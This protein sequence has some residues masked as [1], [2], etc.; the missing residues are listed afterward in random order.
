MQVDRMGGKITTIRPARESE[1]EILT[2]V[3]M[4]S[5][6]HWGYDE[7]FM[8]SCR[9]ELATTVD[10]IRDH[11]V[12]AIVDE[13]DVPVGYYKLIPYPDGGLELSDLFVPR[14]HARN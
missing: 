11:T 10:E 2:D 7:R 3:A 12:R 6:A 4:S 8:A 5:K 13:D 1:T 14:F 9:A